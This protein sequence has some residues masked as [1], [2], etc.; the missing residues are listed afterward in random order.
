M[1]QNKRSLNLFNLECGNR[2]FSVVTDVTYKKSHNPFKIIF[3]EYEFIY[4]GLNS[5]AKKISSDS[6]EN[7]LLEMFY[8]ATEKLVNNKF[9]F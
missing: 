1:K 4:E 7:D 8:R 2:P 3:K 5:A 6:E 9:N